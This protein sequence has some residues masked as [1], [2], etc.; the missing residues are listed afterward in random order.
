MV[1][2]SLIFGN[3]SLLTQRV[4]TDCDTPSF[5]SGLMTAR[6]IRACYEDW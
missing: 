5:H 3:V 6:D 1:S 2:V 4:A